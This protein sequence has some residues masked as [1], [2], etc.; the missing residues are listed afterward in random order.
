MDIVLQKVILKH[1]INSID[2][3]KVIAKIKEIK[4]KQDFDFEKEW[5]EGITIDEARKKSVEFIDSLDWK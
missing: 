5:N 1:W 3:P 2:D 4:E